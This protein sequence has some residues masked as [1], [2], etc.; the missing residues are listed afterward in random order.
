M[1]PKIKQFKL[2]IDLGGTKTEGVILDNEFKEIFRKRISTKQDYNELQKDLVAFYDE[3]SA[4]IDHKPHTFGMGTPGSINKKTGLMKYSNIVSMNGKPFV[5]DIEAKLKRKIA[6][7]ND[8]NC[9]AMAEATMGA[10]KGKKRV[11]GVIMGTGIGGG[12][13][14]KG[15]LVPGLQ[16]VAGEWGHSIIA[17]FGPRCHC[18]KIGCI[19]TFISGRGVENK[20][21]AMYGEHLTMEEIIRKYRFGDDHARIV[22]AEFFIYF[23]K[24]FSNLITILDP[25]IIVIGGG[26]SNID[27]LYTLGISQVRD[28]IFRDDLL[29]PIV[30]NKC[31]DSAGVLG[32][33]L[34]GI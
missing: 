30:R 6:R 5:D 22:M 18:G 13:V 17:S 32:A 4:Y 27:E 11:F 12:L 28:F 14:V 21:F 34:L 15:K 25:D 8:S 1:R 20:F 26:L 33:A 9:F 2:G 23:G 31:G 19:E 29:T 7:Y 3:M 16:E 24:A 10:A